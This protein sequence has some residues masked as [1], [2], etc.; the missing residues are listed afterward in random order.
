MPRKKRPRW[1]PDKNRKVFFEL[2]NEAVAACEKEARANYVIKLL[3]CSQRTAYRLL[4]GP[5]PK[6][7]RAEW[8]YR[9]CHFVKQ[10]PERLLKTEEDYDA[11]LL[12]WTTSAPGPDAIQRA[13]DLGSLL[14]NWAGRIFDLHG[15]FTLHQEGLLPI[16]LVFEFSHSIFQ[17][18]KDHKLAPP[19]VTVYQFRGRMMVSYYEPARGWKSEMELNRDNLFFIY[20]SCYAFTKNFATRIHQAP[21]QSQS[22]AARTQ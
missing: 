7:L 1:I 19:V 3:A 9:L 15:R 4:S 14:I 8:A 22:G 13:C 2:L 11:V 12:G 17:E 10:P 20:K 5:P 21:R 16:R 6:K 18:G